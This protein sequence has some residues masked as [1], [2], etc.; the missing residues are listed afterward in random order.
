[1]TRDTSSK[2][3]DA[4]H[5]V[6]RFLDRSGLATSGARVILLTGD[7]SDRRYY[8]IITNDGS[9]RVLALYADAFE[10]DRLPFVNV[11]ALFQAAS[12]PVPGILGHD[13]ELGVLL[14]Q[15]LGDLTLQ[16]HLGAAAPTE[17]AARYREA[18]SFLVRLQ[19][20]G[21]ELASPSY[22]PYGLAFDRDKLRWELDYFVTHFVEAYRGGRIPDRA[23]DAI[24]REWGPLVDELA[25]EPR[26][27]CH[28]DYHSRNL[29]LH[30]GR[31]YII[32]FQDARMGPNTYDLVSLLRDS[33]VDLAEETVEELIGHFLSPEPGTPAPATA[34]RQEFRRRFDV[35]A[36]QRNLKALGTFGF[37]AA[38]RNNPSYIQYIPRTLRHVRANL[39]RHERF[40]RL[41][42][43]LS[44]HIEELR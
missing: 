20:R 7:A 33:Y 38:V 31:L 44:V 32:D 17:H 5:R 3:D 18:V 1:M 10:F 9:S 28:R 14:L 34:A 4:R 36:L 42:E 35:M 2:D 30:E 6:D 26:V 13:D 27:L 39:L 15:D 12:L 25:S 23:R 29:M 40:A 41:H 22:I 43:L 24:G 16:A 37:Q 19:A 11:A 21:R 8:R